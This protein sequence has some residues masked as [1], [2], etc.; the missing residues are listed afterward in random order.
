MDIRN[1]NVGLTPIDVSRQEA[2]RTDG[3]DASQEVNPT[4]TTPE[5]GQDSVEL[6]RTV[7]PPEI[8][9]SPELQFARKALNSLPDVE[10]DRLEQI[11]ERMQSGYY[12]QGDV[13]DQMADR[14]TEAL[15]GR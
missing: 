8:A 12:T 14:L 9:A 13:L 1:V 6:S 2:V 15:T 7:R 5:I 3:P 11:R 10:G 4:S